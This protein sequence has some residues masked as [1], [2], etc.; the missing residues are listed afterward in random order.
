MLGHYLVFQ[1]VTLNKMVRSSQTLVSK[2]TR[3]SV[4][5]VVSRNKNK[6]CDEKR[7]TTLQY[8]KNAKLILQG[9]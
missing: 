6:Q 7:Y 3:Q 9:F 1:W 5:D 8:M 4:G 2:V